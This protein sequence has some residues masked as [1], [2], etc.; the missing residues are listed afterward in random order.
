MYI[1]K[2][3]ES[4]PCAH[5]DTENKEVDPHLKKLVDEFGIG[6]LFFIAS[7]AAKSM[8]EEQQ[9]KKENNSTKQ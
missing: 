1:L 2:I 8:G 3:D 4:V 9:K 5:D 7:L 6:V